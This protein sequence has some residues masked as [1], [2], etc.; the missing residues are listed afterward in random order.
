MHAA[1]ITT[2]EWRLIRYAVVTAQSDDRTEDK[3]LTALHAKLS[4]LSEHPKLCL[5]IN[6]ERP[7]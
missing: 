3:L 5:M 1:D 6:S 2:D 7:Q 4:K